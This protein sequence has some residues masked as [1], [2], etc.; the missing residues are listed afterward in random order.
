MSEKKKCYSDNVCCGNSGEQLQGRISRVG[1]WKARQAV[2]KEAV[3][4]WNPPTQGKQKEQKCKASPG[5]TDSQ[6]RRVAR[7]GGRE[8]GKRRGREKER[9]SVRLKERR[10]RT[11]L[12]I[13]P[14]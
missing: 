5:Y 4:T 10:L 7:E 13:C 1:S 8:E 12:A 14:I 9:I 6:S 11:G 3:H 2:S